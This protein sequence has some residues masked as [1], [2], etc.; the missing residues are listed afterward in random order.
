MSRKKTP[1][2]PFLPARRPR[3][4][5]QI[6]YNNSNNR[7]SPFF[8]RLPPELR[9]AILTT[10]LGGRTLHAHLDFTHPKVARQPRAGPEQRQRRPRPD[11]WVGRLLTTIL[12]RK[13]TSG[14]GARRAE[15]PAPHVHVVPDRTRPPAWQWTGCACHRLEELEEEHLYRLLSSCRNVGRRLPPDWD[16]CCDS[17]WFCTC[18]EWRGKEEEEEEWRR[19]ECGVGVMGWLLTCRQA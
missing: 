15:G 10:A 8:R 14:G 1:P 17:S 16:R 12:P 6:D 4:L 7:N 9:R 13:L 18:E 2:P 3:R 19:Q 11:R 5:T